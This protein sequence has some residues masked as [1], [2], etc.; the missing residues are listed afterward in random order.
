V[1]AHWRAVSFSL[2]SDREAENATQLDP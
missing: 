1:S 2:Y